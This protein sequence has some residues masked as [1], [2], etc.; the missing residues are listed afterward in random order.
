MSNCTAK[1]YYKAVN[2]ELGNKL[3]SSDVDLNGANKWASI[4]FTSDKEETVY[5]FTIA[6]AE[7]QFYYDLFDR[8]YTT[9]TS[10]MYATEQILKIHEE[11][12]QKILDF[13]V[14]KMPFGIFEKKHKNEDMFGR[15]H[16][17]CIV[18]DKY[19]TNSVIKNLIKNFKKNDEQEF[20]KHQL[21]LSQE[22]MLDIV[23]NFRI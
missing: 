11:M 4:Y 15:K 1:A 22:E 9:F 8:C 6:T 10:K 23:D 5:C 7:Y 3:Y 16:F 12:K 19:I 17:H 20:S 14:N 18:P 13:D 2:N 21:S